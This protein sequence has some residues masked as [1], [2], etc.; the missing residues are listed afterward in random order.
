ME[1]QEQTGVGR[2][3]CYGD[4][5]PDLSRVEFNKPCAGR[6]FAVQVNSCGLGVQSREM[7][8]DETAWEECVR[9][10]D[11][12]PCYDLS[13]AKLVLGEALQSRP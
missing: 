12:R 6:A 9:C 13:T 7:K 4:L 3:R 1:A 11:Y 8:V 10:P 5:F 2:R